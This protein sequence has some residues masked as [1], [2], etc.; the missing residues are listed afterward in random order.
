MVYIISVG[1]GLKRKNEL[2]KLEK[3]INQAGKKLT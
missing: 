2:K 3:F 1:I